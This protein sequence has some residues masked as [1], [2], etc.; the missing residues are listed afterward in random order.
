MAGRGSREFLIQQLSW[1]GKMLRQDTEAD[2]FGL[3]RRRATA[4]M[5]L[6]KIEVEKRISLLRSSR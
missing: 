6:E 1:K 5:R 2:G 4:D 3:G